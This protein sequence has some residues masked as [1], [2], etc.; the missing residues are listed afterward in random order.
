MGRLHIPF[1]LRGQL[2]FDKQ[3]ASVSVSLDSLPHRSY[4]LIQLTL[5]AQQ[6]VA[7][8]NI[9]CRYKLYNTFLAA[10]RRRVNQTLDLS[11]CSKTCL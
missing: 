3:V 2:K 6:N 11:Y 8:H 9:P 5:L 4:Q 10:F 7:L 1:Y